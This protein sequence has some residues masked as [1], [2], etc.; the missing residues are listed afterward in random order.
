VTDSVPI[1]DE[2]TSR[3]LFDADLGWGHR[4]EG[5]DEMAHVAVAS[6]PPEAL[7]RFE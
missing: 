7:L 5:S 2:S 6:N 4:V 1:I 3:H